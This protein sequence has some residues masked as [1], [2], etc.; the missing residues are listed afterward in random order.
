MQLVR[1]SLKPFCLSSLHKLSAIVAAEPA[2]IVA[3]YGSLYK[4]NLP[5]SRIAI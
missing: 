1:D 3:N 4:R 5:R 2:A